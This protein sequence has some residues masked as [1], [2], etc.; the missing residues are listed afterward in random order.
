[1][2]NRI[3]LT[4]LIVFSAIIITFA[5]SVNNNSINTRLAFNV[6]SINKVAHVYI[7]SSFNGSSNGNGEISFGGSSD[8][9]FQIFP[10]NGV[11][12]IVEVNYNT[13]DNSSVGNL[14]PTIID[15]NGNIYR[16]RL[17]GNI[18]DTIFSGM[19]IDG[20]LRGLDGKKDGNTGDIVDYN[21]SG[22]ASI[23]FDIPNN[24]KKPYLTLIKNGLSIPL[25]ITK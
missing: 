8:T 13:N 6:T 3:Y 21:K 12:L 4:I 17:V 11:F 22:S 19:I 24:I 14:S 7:K 16:Q 15:D 25:I 1:M 18:G 5:Q 10:T 23:C 20:T 2:L 9:T